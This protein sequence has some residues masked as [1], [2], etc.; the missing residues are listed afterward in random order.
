MR[1][2]LGLTH[3]KRVKD[4]CQIKAGD[5]LQIYPYLHDIQWFFHGF[6]LLIRKDGVRAIEEAFG[7]M[8]CLIAEGTL[9]AKKKD[10]KHVLQSQPYNMSARRRMHIQA[11]RIGMLLG[12]LLNQPDAVTHL[13]V[14]RSPL[15]VA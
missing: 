7:K 10:L 5:A 1:C 3:C 11:L 14:P 12:K 8:L 4:I 6:N 15:K 2:R 13:L 9:V